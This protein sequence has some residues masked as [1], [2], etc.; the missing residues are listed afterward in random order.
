[1]AKIKDKPV[2]VRNIASTKGFTLIEIVATLLIIGIISVIAVSKMGSTDVYKLVAE[3][4][5]LRNHLRF[6]QGKSM[7]SLKSEPW[8]IKLRK[9]KYIL[10][11][12]GKKAKVN[13]PNEDSA[14]HKLS[15]GVSITTGKG[16]T[17]T[18][19]DFGSPG[20]SDITITLNTSNDS[21]TLT[22]TK[23]TGFIHTK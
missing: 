5:I 22:I 11:K 10:Q 14:K 20:T 2:S 1:M 6:A 18:F 23:E 3:V 16:T 12:S 19:D 21:R 17:V 4:E 8:G 9:N 15:T 13:L 7:V